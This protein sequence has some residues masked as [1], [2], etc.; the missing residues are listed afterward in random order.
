M[1]RVTAVL[2]FC[3]NI[4]FACLAQKSVSNRKPNII[5]VLTDDMGYSDISCYGNPLIKTPFIDA[6]AHK[7]VMAT[8]F[9]TTSPTCS[10][11]RA[12]LLTGRYCSR[13]GV[14]RPLGPGEKTALPG[15]EITIAEMLKTSGYRTA[16]VGKWHLGD[17]GTSLPNKQGF[18]HFY[19]INIRIDSE[20]LFIELPIFRTTTKI[21]RSYLPN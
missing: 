10:P 7:G 19:G 2:C 11:S 6:M 9:I 13:S 14:N 15:E 12:S 18:D 21:S 17:Y 3:T 8:S 5:L 4:F 16:L 20:Q 1:K